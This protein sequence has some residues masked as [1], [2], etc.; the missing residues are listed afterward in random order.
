[1]HFSMIWRIRR[2]KLYLITKPFV[3]IVVGA[4]DGFSL[5]IHPIIVS[6]HSVHVPTHMLI[7]RLVF[8]IK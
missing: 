8:L 6:A 2:I 7:F 4:D 5:F 3:V 1:M